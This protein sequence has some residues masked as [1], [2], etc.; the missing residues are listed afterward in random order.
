MLNIP[1]PAY[2]P[3]MFPGFSDDF[4]GLASQRVRGGDGTEPG[5]SGANH[6]DLRWRH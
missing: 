2:L 1:R 5:Y 6:E 4:L 3:W